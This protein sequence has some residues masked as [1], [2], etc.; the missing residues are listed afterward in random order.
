MVGTHEGEADG[1][2]PTGRKIELHTIT[3]VISDGEIQ[4]V[5]EYFE[6]QGRPSQ[7]E[8]VE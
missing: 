3:T 1:V 7:L 2:P 5:R 4:E 6:P 8:A